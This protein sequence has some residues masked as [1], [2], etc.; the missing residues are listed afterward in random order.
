MQAKIRHKHSMSHAWI[1]AWLL[2]QIRGKGPCLR[3]GFLRHTS[4]HQ[5][6]EK[7]FTSYVWILHCCCCTSGHQAKNQ[8]FTI[9]HSIIA[10]AF[11]CLE[12][13]LHSRARNVTQKF[14]ST[15]HNYISGLFVLCVMVLGNKAHETSWNYT[16]LGCTPNMFGGTNFS[17]RATK[18]PDDC[19]QI[20]WD[21]K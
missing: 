15:I 21:L 17:Q 14:T 6:G 11:F 1:F 18:T 5:F 9:R 3:L 2:A 4:W 20:L 16:F 7:M 10:C 13:Y 12:N 19:T 8:Y